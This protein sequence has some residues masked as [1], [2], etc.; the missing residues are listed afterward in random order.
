MVLR[1]SDKNAR[2]RQIRRLRIR[3]LDALDALSKAETEEQRAAA[4]KA[5]SDALHSLLLGT[6][7]PKMLE[8]FSGD[9]PTLL[10]PSL[11][12]RSPSE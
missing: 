10:Q 1:P 7:S 11:P 2:S 3:A 8:E 9:Y 12:L 4:N 6:L 5:C